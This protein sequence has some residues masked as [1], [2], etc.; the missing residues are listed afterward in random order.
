MSTPW[1]TSASP[2]SSPANAVAS[3]TGTAS[4]TPAYRVRDLLREEA[5][6][7]RPH[8]ER[9]ASRHRVHD[10][11]EGAEHRRIDEVDRAHHRHPASKRDH[12]ER[13]AEIA[14][15]QETSRHQEAVGLHGTSAR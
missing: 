14:A 11:D 9:R 4:S 7:S 3:T 15:A 8:E 2:L 5:P 13:E 12:G 1:T 10:L 6:L